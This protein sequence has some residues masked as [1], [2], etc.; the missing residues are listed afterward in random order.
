MSEDRKLAT[1]RRVSKIEAI[2]D[3][4]QI[5]L[6]HIDGWQCV[7]KKGEFVEGMLGVYFEIDSLLPEIPV[8]DFL[9]S[10]GVKRSEDGSVGYRVRTVKLKGQVSQGLLM[11]M[12]SFTHDRFHD[13]TEPPLQEGE[14]VTDI[15]NIKKYEAPLSDELR[16]QFGGKVRRYFPEFLRKTDEE[17]IQNL[18]EYFDKYRHETFEITEKI[19]GSSMTAYLNNGEF[20][21]CSRRLE[22]FESEKNAFWQMARSIK[23]EE[24]LQ[25]Y[26]K[27]I[28][29]QGELAGEGIQKNRIKLRGRKF[30]LFNV[31]LIDEKRYALPIERH[32][33]FTWLFRHGMGDVIDEAGIPLFWHVP[34]IEKKY[35]V[36]EH[37]PTMDELLAYAQGESEMTKGCQR[38]GIVFKSD[39]YPGLSFKAISNKYLLKHEE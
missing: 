35:P 33:I 25:E 30:F 26:E 15:L 31:W 9:K 10:R 13:C 28:A 21:I 16:A 32:D 2:A 17:R 19:D 3:A 29:L 36:F 18:P 5:E 12:D 37:Y 38:E 39:T 7:V 23:M 6:A 1:I 8:F 11:P 20:G 22:L 14:D 24:A 27:N 4:D 34:I